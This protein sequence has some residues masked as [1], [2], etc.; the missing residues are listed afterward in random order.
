MKIKV[1]FDIDG[2]ISEYPKFWLDYILKQTGNNFNDI[3]QAKNLLGVREYKELKSTYRDSEDKFLI[4]V[5]DE[6]VKLSKI[7]YKMGGEVYINSTRPFKEYP[8]MIG[9]TTEW[10]LRNGLMFEDVGSKTVENLMKQKCIFHVD[11]EIVDCLKIAELKTI[12]KV[13]LLE[14]S[15]SDVFI[16]SKIELVLLGD[17]ETII[18]KEMKKLSKSF[19]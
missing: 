13:F 4:P 14:K 17:L 19:D 18:I 7:I 2:T 9:R 5:R 3:N 15:I 1:S 6:I 10:L 8:N 11:D 12:K 16:N